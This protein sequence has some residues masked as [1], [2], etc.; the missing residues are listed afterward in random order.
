MSKAELIVFTDIEN[1]V[2]E[3]I[4]FNFEELK[5]WLDESLDKYKGLVVT[6]DGVKDAKADRAKLNKLAKA[7]DD[8]KKAIKDACLAPYVEFEKKIKELT[9]EIKS[10]SSSIDE[11]I[12]SFEQAEKD[13]KREGVETFYSIEAGEEF[14]KLVPISKVWNDRW[15]NATY[16]VSDIEKEIKEAVFKAKKD[17]QII[18]A[19]GSEYQQQMMDKYLQTLDMSQAMAEKAR[20]EEQAKAQAEY[21][22]KMAE[23][24]KAQAEREQRTVEQTQVVVENPAEKAPEPTAEPK[25]VV[26]QLYTYALRF[27]ATME[28]SRALRQFIDE[29]GIKYEKVVD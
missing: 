7:I 24:A 20:L 9:G 12:K 1:Q 19:I 25:E 14:E 21:K 3:V 28:Q 22:K 6:E 26:G 13:R 11:Q 2:P 8:R 27:H 5:A 23:Q 29:N 15:L 16:K 17:I 4:E 18:E 10:V